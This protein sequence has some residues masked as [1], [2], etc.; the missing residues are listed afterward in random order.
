MCDRPAMY[1][2]SSILHAGGALSLISLCP[3]MI[4]ALK[5]GKSRVAIRAEDAHTG[6]R[7]S[8]RLQWSMNKERIECFVRDSQVRRQSKEPFVHH[9]SRDTFIASLSSKDRRRF[10]A[11]RTRSCRSSICQARADCSPKIRK[12]PWHRRSIIHNRR[13]R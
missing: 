11:Y 12:K 7:S 3:F 9:N 2:H 1:W 8:N 4:V 10:G 5:Q 13:S 6:S